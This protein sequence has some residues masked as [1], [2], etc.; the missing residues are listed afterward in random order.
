MS[1][2]ASLTRDEPGTRNQ[3]M[4][5]VE[6]A[7]ADQYSVFRQAWLADNE[8]ITV[9]NLA[10]KFLPHSPTGHHDQQ[11]YVCCENSSLALKK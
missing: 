7:M 6:V 11:H 3:Q 9:S 1:P 2:N 8:W 5:E 4:N 10:R